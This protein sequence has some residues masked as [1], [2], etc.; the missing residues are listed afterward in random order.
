[1]KSNFSSENLPE[2]SSKFFHGIAPIKI[3]EL[4]SQGM[5][6]KE[7]A[8]ELGVCHVTLARRMADIEAKQGILLK[9]RSIQTLELTGLQ[10]RILETIT[11]EKIKQASLL[12]LLKA[13]GLL[14]KAELGLKGEKPKIEGLAAYLIYM[15]NMEKEKEAR[16]DPGSRPADRRRLTNKG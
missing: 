3:Y 11:P 13:F 15:E 7:M 2:I 12:D 1:L 16:E 8:K 6:Q 4:S 14:K 9:Y 10:F 5:T